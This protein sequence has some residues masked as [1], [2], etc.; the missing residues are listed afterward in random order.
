[1]FFVVNRNEKGVT[2]WKL[3][4]AKNF[5]ALLPYANM[6]KEGLITTVLLAFFTVLL[7]FVLG[8]VLSV[9]RMSNIRPFLWLAHAFPGTFGFFERDKRAACCGTPVSFITWPVQSP[10]LPGHCLCGGHPLH[11][12]AGAGDGDLLRRVQPA[13]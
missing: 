4:P 8:L 2:P 6:F 10:G 12:C 3:Y 11:P 13:L 9:M 7:G 1:M 5:E